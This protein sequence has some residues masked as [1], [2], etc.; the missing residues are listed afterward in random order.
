MLRFSVCQHESFRHRTVVV[1]DVPNI[2]SQIVSPYPVREEFVNS[3]LTGYWVADPVAALLDSDLLRPVSTTELS[4]F[5]GSDNVHFTP[6][7]YTKLVGG[8]TNCFEKAAKKLSMSAASSSV[9]GSSGAPSKFYWRGFTSN[10]GA[11]RTGFKYGQRNPG[12]G[13]YN[14]RPRSHPYRGAK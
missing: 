10:H 11:V 7:G 2:D 12:G 1:V 9:S 8:I 6:L 14:K 3:S 4:H 13:D 5:L